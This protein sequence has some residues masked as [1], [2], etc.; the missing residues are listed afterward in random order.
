MDAEAFLRRALQDLEESAS[1]EPVDEYRMVRASGL[2][3]L[4]IADNPSLLDRVAWGRRATFRVHCPD[5]NVS[6]GRSS[7]IGQALGS[8]MLIGRWVAARD[9]YTF[10]DL[11]R[12]EFLGHVVAFSSW[13]GE[14][15]VKTVIRIG[16]T[17]FGGVHF[18]TPV[19]PGEQEVELVLRALDDGREPDTNTLC[20]LLRE[21]C[22]TVVNSLQRQEP[23]SRGLHLRCRITD[24]S[25]KPQEGSAETSGQE[26]CSPLRVALVDL[27]PPVN[28]TAT[29]YVNSSTRNFSHDAPPAAF[30]P[31][32]ASI[33]LRSAVRNLGASFR[34]VCDSRL[35][36]RHSV[37]PACRPRRSNRRATS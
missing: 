36:R 10:R 7:D 27:L 29:R 33:D 5:L 11:S 6:V 34:R 9:G 17:A 16:A 22:A 23:T 12:A 19:N 31:I 28:V 26:D 35:T 32:V 25:E 20:K 8:G 37:R 4:L 1:A 21:I 18:A 14:L 2:L 24:S 13:T 3:R 30:C 15:T